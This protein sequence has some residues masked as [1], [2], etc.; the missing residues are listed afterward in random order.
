ML[1]FQVIESSDLSN[2]HCMHVKTSADPPNWCICGCDM[3]HCILA[4]MFIVYKTK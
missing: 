1:S 4:S 2:V 3:F